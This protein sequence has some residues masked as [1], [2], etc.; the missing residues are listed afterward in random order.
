MEASPFAFSVPRY[1][2][3][4]ISILSECEV[5]ATLEAEDL[6][7]IL[8][9]FPKDGSGFFSK[10]ELIR[11]YRYLRA[12]GHFSGD[13]EALLEKLRMKP[14]RTQSGVS[15]V[16]VLTKP[17]PCPGRC[18][19]CPSDVRMPK[20]YL[21]DE[22]G[23]QR[24]AEHQFD[25][26]GQTMARLRTLFN[27][28]HA[29]D[30]VELIV[31]GGTWSSYPEEYQIWFI[32][33]C[34]QALNEFD[35]L[36]A[37]PQGAHSSFEI[38]YRDLLGQIPRANGKGRYNR[39]VS[40]FQEARGAPAEGAAWA[41][42]ERVHLENESAGARCV[43]L[44]LET[45]PDHLSLA[46]AVHMRRLGTTKVQIG[47]QSLSDNVL[48][49]NRRGHDVASTR[50]AMSVLREVGFK[51]HAHWMPNLYGSSPQ[52]DLEEF[53]RLFSDRDFRPDELKIYPCSLIESAELMDF[54]ESGDWRPYE[55][56]ELLALLSR[57]LELTPAY[58]RVSRMIRDIPGTD[59]VEG[60]RV[61]NFRQLVEARLQREEIGLV[62]IRS[63]E[64]GAEPVDEDDLKLETVEYESSRGQEL[65][66]QYTTSAGR[67]VAFL[68]LSLPSREARIAEI[69]RSALLR[70]V[71]V[72]G[73]VVG[74]GRQSRRRAQH[75][76]LGAALISK[77]AGLSLSAGYQDLAVISSIG[78]REYYRSRGF[79]DG[80]L[81]QHLSV[82]GLESAPAAASE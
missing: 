5:A 2:R 58:C 22:P 4:L 13:E 79:E 67:L 74:I 65:F 47:Y 12:R 68:R 42:L 18:V 17:Y 78:T 54:Y 34:F 57:C 15:P 51:I 37:E 71:H 48:A 27:N 32:V 11:G 8:R 40:E 60:N 80:D 24:A 76:G 31:L 44:V 28:G 20:S 39:V 82:C 73:R 23:A 33:R 7:S 77:A 59:I 72:Y 26:Y 56:E 1:E 35:P 41:E 16:T 61:T 62:E 46:E 14:I 50:A 55:H 38:D 25:P 45:R 66:L 6:R 53:E 3:E 9:R 43:G 69:R 81:Y 29:V 52:A 64:I 19:F 21:S 36:D 75:L 10:S 70:E 49:L 30:K 63:R